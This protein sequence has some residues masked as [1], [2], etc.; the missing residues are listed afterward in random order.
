MFQF[1]EILDL[2]GLDL[3]GFP[4]HFF[5]TS[6]NN[7]YFSS[8][9]TYCYLF[10][11]AYPEAKVNESGGERIDVP[12]VL[13]RQSYGLGRSPKHS[14]HSCHYHTHECLWLKGYIKDLWLERCQCPKH[15]GQIKHLWKKN[16]CNF[17]SNIFGGESLRNICCSTVSLATW[18]VPKVTHLVLPNM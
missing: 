14:A 3:K 1:P 7:T 9:K 5:S 17:C 13:S 16:L 8:G 6:S 12:S 11:H 4:V 18:T 2:W 10:W 15:G